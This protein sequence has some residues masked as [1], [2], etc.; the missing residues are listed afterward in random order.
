M[1]ASNEIKANFFS[2]SVWRAVALLRC[3]AVGNT[4]FRK[5]VDALTRGTA[6]AMYSACRVELERPNF[7]TL[8][9]DNPTV[10]HVMYTDI[11][12][13]VLCVV[14]LYDL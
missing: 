13:S 12:Y 4:F 7:R 9:S 8:T 6:E 14:H 5:S 10:R 3:A 1:H 11:A 2:A